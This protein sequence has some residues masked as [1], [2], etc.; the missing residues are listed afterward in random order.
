MPL[1]TVDLVPGRTQDQKDALTKRIIQ[2]MDE[3]MGVPASAIWVMYRETEAADWFVADK[4][5]A[6]IRKER[7]AK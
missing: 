4:S 7:E 5:I 1:V 2:A 3:E 6:Q